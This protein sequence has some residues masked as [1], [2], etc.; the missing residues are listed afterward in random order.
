MTV[1]VGICSGEGAVLAADSKVT[2]G[3]VHQTYKPKLTF[4]GGNG[5]C[6]GLAGAGY[7]DLMDESFQEI[8]EGLES[9]KKPTEKTIRASLKKS[10]ALLA[11]LYPEEIKE[12][13]WLCVIAGAPNAVRLMRFWRHIPSPNE[14]LAIIGCGKASITDHLSSWVT[15]RPASNAEALRWAT[16]LIMQA[17]A[18]VPGCGGPINA[19]VFTPDGKVGEK[20]P[21]ETAQIETELKELHLELS[22]VFQRVAIARP[23]KTEADMVLRAFGER[24]KRIIS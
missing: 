9:L 21:E 4:M 11:G 3:N 22:A 5:F 1:C 6:V 23:N 10:L 17:S 12:Q 19:L 8:G 2:Y 16:F 20:R 18:F 13:E 24:V 15:N 7:K 14:E